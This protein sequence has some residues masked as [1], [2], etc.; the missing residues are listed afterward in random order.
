MVIFNKQR[1]ID[2]LEGNV[3]LFNKMSPAK[4]N[5]KKS[6]AVM[7]GKKLP[8]NLILP[9][10]L[11]WNKGGMKYMGVFLGEESVLE[12]N[13]ENALGKI[14]ARLK[15]W[16]WLLPSISYRGRMLVINNL[17]SS[18]LWHRFICVD[19]LPKLLSQIQAVFVDFFWDKLHWIPQAAGHDQQSQKCCA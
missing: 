7:V 15:K 12:K 19:P 6:E 14:E 17:V 11:T 1:D 18:S 5:W 13:W 10:G 9:G 8:D 3:D 16:K 4:V 2:I